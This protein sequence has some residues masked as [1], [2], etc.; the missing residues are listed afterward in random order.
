[1]PAIAT[2]TI[3]R[4]NFRSTLGTMPYEVGPTLPTEFLVIEVIDLAIRA[5]HL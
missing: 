5:F 1:M 2:K 4:K 3:V